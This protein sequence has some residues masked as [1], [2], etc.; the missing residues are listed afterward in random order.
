MFRFKVQTLYKLGSILE[1][2]SNLQFH[3]DDQSSPVPDKVRG[4][5][6]STLEEFFQKGYFKNLGLDRAHSRVETVYEYLTSGEE[7]TCAGFTRILGQLQEIVEA[8]ENTRF[9]RSHLKEFGDSAILFSS[10]YYMLV[11]EYATYLDTQQSINLAI[12]RCFESESIDFA[13]PTQTIH[14]ESLPASEDG[15]T[16]IEKITGAPS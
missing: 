16:P 4:L 10:Q 6:V 9:D 5:A 15:P 14:V 11:P 8:E 1:K 13:F 12:H 2:L 7:V 3:P